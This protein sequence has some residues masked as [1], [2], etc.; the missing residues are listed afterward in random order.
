FEPGIGRNRGAVLNERELFDAC[1]AISNQATDI[2]KRARG[3][4]DVEPPSVNFCSFRKLR[5]E[6]VVSSAPRSCEQRRMKGTKVADHA[7]RRNDRR[8]DCGYRQDRYAAQYPPTPPYSAH[9]V[10]P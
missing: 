3:R 10:R 6:A 4:D 7:P 5:T 2:L 1:V 8:D 9:L